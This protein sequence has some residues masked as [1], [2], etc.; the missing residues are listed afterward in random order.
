MSDI[1]SLELE[2][3]KNPNLDSCIPLVS[4]YLEKQR[5]MEAMVVCKKGIKTTPQDPRGRSLLVRVYLEQGKLPKAQQELDKAMQEFPGNPSGLAM[6]G[7]MA[8]KQGDATGAITFLQQSLQLNPNQPEAMSW[9]QQLGATPAMPATQQPVMQQ[10][11][12]QQPVMQQ[13]VMQQPVMQQ[14]AMQQ[15]AMQQ[16]AMQQPVMQQPVMQQPVMQQPVMQSPSAMHG[17][18]PMQPPPG[19]DAGPPPGAPPP[20]ASPGADGVPM[21]HVSD[22]F[23]ADALGFS[24][25]ST[26][27]IETA[28]PGRLTI[29]GFVPKSTGSIKTTIAVALGFFAVAAALITWQVISAQQKREIA[30]HYKLIVE[31]LEE[32]KYYRY[33]EAIGVANK[34][35]AIDDSHDLTLAAVAYAHAVLADDHDEE[36][37]LEKA[38]HIEARA[39]EQFSG[40]N[41]DQYRIA[42]AAIIA[43]LDGKASEGY[44][45]VKAIQERGARSAFIDLEAYNLLRVLKP[46]DPETENQLKITIRN[47]VSEARVFNHLGWI[48]LLQEE[49]QKADR[50]FTS[51]VQNSTNHPQALLGGALKD[52]GRNLGMKERQVEVDKAVR[53]V[54]A[55]PKEELSVPVL[56]LAHFTR[57]L[58][59]TYQ[60][61]DAKAKKDLEKAYKLHGNPYFYFGEGT[62][63]LRR[64]DFASAV[65]VLQKG[66]GKDPND[67][68]LL[69]KLA[70]AQIGAKNGSAALSTL[71]RVDSQL[72]NDAEALV[73][74]GKALS[75]QGKCSDAIT[76]FEKVTLKDHKGTAFVD[77]QIGI[78]EVHI[79]CSKK[80]KLAEKLI[81]GVLENMPQ[82]VQKDE[83]SDAWCTLGWAYESGKA[84][85]KAMESYM[86][87][88]ELYIYNPMCHYRLVKFDGKSHCEKCM[89]ADPIGWCATVC[90]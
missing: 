43:R 12:M 75:Q 48:H 50:F 9:L 23:A 22:F 76:A 86:Q 20:G 33:N 85:E 39:R 80:P 52:I 83:Q 62:L 64:L 4:A 60:G 18:P 32:D 21:E 74:R 17:A 37:A 90:K 5:F 88:V 72:P 13:P 67:P 42:A 25:S 65:D 29:L 49:F 53:K 59:L 79:T 28:G 61:K 54:F 56:A 19:T 14:P 11:V 81:L 89:A 6:Q 77:A 87:G 63:H 78:A 47:A 38:K 2:F 7:L 40:E 69:K 73:L 36:G 10:P 34:V 71:E 66:A 27:G 45:E 68:R 1:H 51:A 26:S 15:P 3:A 30:E 44:A 35:F 82:S 84:R 8:M 16:P 46:S 70:E 31:A 58:L 55:A 24:D 57:G 41:D